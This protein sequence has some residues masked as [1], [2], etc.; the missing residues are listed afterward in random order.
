LREPLR[1]GGSSAA[2]KLLTNTK[3]EGGKKKRA[4]REQG[5][6]NQQRT[7]FSNTS[8][9]GRI[10]GWMRTGQETVFC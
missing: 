1:W 10:D 6:G 2:S 8:A 7:Y 9:P 4:Q 5:T 3:E